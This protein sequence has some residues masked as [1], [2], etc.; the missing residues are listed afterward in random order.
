[1]VLKT[2]HC[3]TLLRLEL[4]GIIWID[5]RNITADRYRQLHTIPESNLRI[6]PICS[7]RRITHDSVPLRSA[8][9]AEIQKAQK[10]IFRFR[11]SRRKGYAAWCI[12]ASLYIRIMHG[13]FGRFAW[14]GRIG[15]S[16]QLGIGRSFLLLY[17]PMSLRQR[18][19]SP[20]FCA[21]WYDLSLNE[22]KR[23]KS[24]SQRVAVFYRSLLMCVAGLGVA[25]L[26][27]RSACVGP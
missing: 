4:H 21:S 5:L 17:V 19:K 9:S 11:K 22:R 16:E 26:G 6:I 18:V 8:E 1:M 20:R 14:C 15:A 27:L 10:G 25:P 24:A 2:R 7:E 3:A 23:L 13:G 12:R